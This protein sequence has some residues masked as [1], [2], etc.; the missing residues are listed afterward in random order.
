MQMLI[1]HKCSRIY[2]LQAFCTERICFITARFKICCISTVS[3][4][5][6]YTSLW[7]FPRF[8]STQETLTQ[9][10]NIAA[11]VVETTGVYCAFNNFVASR[12]RKIL[13][14]IS[15]WAHSWSPTYVLVLITCL[16]K[17]HQKIKV[18]HSL[19]ITAFLVRN[20]NKFLET[21]SYHPFCCYRYQCKFANIGLGSFRK[22]C[23]ADIQ[24][25]TDS[26]R[27]YYN[28]CLQLAWTLPVKVFSCTLDS[29]I[30][31]TTA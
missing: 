23:F 9:I 15:L 28:V 7:Y 8:L 12:I 21:W 26:L 13:K 11:F 29:T 25:N 17:T 1:S 27:F 31:Y 19:S 2:I 6:Y 24:P 20:A 5:R 14:M 3:A 18:L 30:T 10:I 4:S 16:Y 22:V